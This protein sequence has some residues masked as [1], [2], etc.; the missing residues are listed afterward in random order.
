MYIRILVLLC[1]LAT[2]G[3]YLHR[4]QQAGRLQRVDDLFLDFLVANGR[5]RFTAPPPKAESDVVFIRMRAEEAT[6]YASWPPPPVDWRTVLTGLKAYEPS[7]VVIT[8][9]LTWGRPAPDFVPA[10]ADALL[11]FPSVVLGVETEVGEGNR[12]TNSFMGDL[13]DSIPRFQRV[14]GDL[15]LAPTLLSLVTAPDPAVRHQGELGLLSAHLNKDTWLLPYAVREGETLVPSILAQ[16]MARLTKTPYSLHRI[17]LGPGGGAYLQEGLFVPLEV[18]G[19]FSLDA[20]STVPTVNA[21]TLMAGTLADGTS[22]EDKAALGKGKVMVVGIDRD[23]AGEPPVFARLY[24]QALSQILALPRLRML[25]PMEQWGAWGVAVLAALWMLLRVR[26]SR[27]IFM[28]LGLVL[29]AL[30]LS[31]TLF[32]ASLLWCPPTM[33]V[34]LI[35]TGALVATILGVKGDVKETSTSSPA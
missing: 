24:A 17:R 27:A 7:V 1:C 32:Q 5:E 2:T 3:W 31:F 15:H 35:L 8:T 16:T 6:D 18:M 12:D 22:V 21:L 11:P 34:A 29:V 9:P 30:A 20:K 19:E 14:D 28:G 13:H 23:G 10:V 26:R 4:E 33:P 25:S